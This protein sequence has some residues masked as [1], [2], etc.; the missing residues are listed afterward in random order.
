PAARLRPGQAAQPGQERH[1]QVAA[2]SRASRHARGQSRGEARGSVGALRA[3]LWGPEPARP[4]R[5]RRLR[6]CAPGARGRAP[7]ATRRRP[8][9]PQARLFALLVALFRMVLHHGPRR[10]FLGAATVT[11]ALLGALL[12]VLVHALFLVTDTLEG[13]LAGHA[14]LLGGICYRPVQAAYH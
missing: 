12:D 8:G 13:L 2:A 4:A 14:R 10:D 3:A 7:R 6:G 9:R 11:A 5:T 1:R